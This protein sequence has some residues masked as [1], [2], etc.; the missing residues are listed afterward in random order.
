MLK[1]PNAAQESLRSRSGVTQELDGRHDHV[2]VLLLLVGGQ[3][4]ELN[5][6][7]ATKSVRVLGEPELV[8]GTCELSLLFAR[9]LE[10]C[11]WGANVVNS[12][13]CELAHGL[14]ALL[15]VFMELC[16]RDVDVDIGAVLD[17]AHARSEKIASCCLFTSAELREP[18]VVVKHASDDGGP[19]EV[20]LRSFCH[21][22]TDNTRKLLDI[23]AGSHGVCVVC[24]VL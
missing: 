19:E 9:Q 22:T 13:N 20:A 23:G 6:K 7:M 8:D 17:G 11:A 1:R 12:G 5:V 10:V 18:V 14:I 4:R 15:S 24:W 16:V 3:E 2:N 21:P